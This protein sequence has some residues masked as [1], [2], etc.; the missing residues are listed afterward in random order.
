MTMLL[1][2]IIAVPLVYFGFYSLRFLANQLLSFRYRAPEP[3]SSDTGEEEVTLL[4][5]AYRVDAAFPER[6]QIIR[7]QLKAKKLTENY[8]IYILFQHCEAEIV[9]K[10]APFVNG[11]AIASFDHCA[12][13]R[14]H[15]ALRFAADQIADLWPKTDY[16]LLLDPDNVPQPEAFVQFL[17]HLPDQPDIVQGQRIPDCADQSAT[18]FDALSE[19]LNDIQFRRAKSVCHLPIELAGS[20]MMLRFPLFRQA[21]QQFDTDAPGMDKNLLIQMVKLKPNLAMIYDEQ[22]QVV[23]QKTADVQQLG[24]QRL[25][26]FAN[27]YFNAIRYFLPLAKLSVQS[28]SIGPLDYALTLARP[29][30]S[31]QLVLS[32]TALFIELPLYFSDVIAF[33]WMVLAMFPFLIASALF[34]IQMRSLVPIKQLGK[35]GVLVLR[36]IVSALRSLSPKWHGTFISTRNG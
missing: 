10:A 2:I 12:G 9:H 26:W 6:V 18:G 32:L 35:M 31:V 36:N 19:R 13:N 15:H 30:R 20:G 33:P 1:A 29:P 27:Q 7:K 22:I 4:I 24:R 8:R 21:V 14:Y 23:D 25:R 34:M 5:P 16:L 28:G 17:R 11:F 3:R